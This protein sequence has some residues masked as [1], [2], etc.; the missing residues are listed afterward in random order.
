MYTRAR[1]KK[2]TESMEVTTGERDADEEEDDNDSQLIKGRQ[3]HQQRELS[4]TN[5]PASLS[6]LGGKI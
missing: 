3:Y 1:R 4:T 5:T 2:R 6:S